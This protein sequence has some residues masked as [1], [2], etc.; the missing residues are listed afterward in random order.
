MIARRTVLLLLGLL[1]VAGPAL[2]QTSAQLL[3]KGIF[4]EDTVGDVDGAIKIY[5]QVLVARFLPRSVAEQAQL[6]LADS[7]RR[8]GQPQAAPGAAQVDP[9][10]C[11]GIFSR[12]YDVNRPV[13]VSGEVTQVSWI[14]PQSVVY[15]K[16]ND[17][18]L[19]GM[20]IAAPN[21]MIRVGMT[22]TSFKLGEQLLIDGFMAKGEG[23][24]CPAALPNACAQ[25]E[26]GALHGSARTIT[27]E[28]GRKIFDRGEAERALANAQ[29]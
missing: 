29:Q 22:K 28:D 23:A 25:F 1:L 19:W 26:N 24:P 20:T 3:E 16:G 9:N 5:R 7:L 12:N 18:N 6:R 8:K 2:A 4:T 13:T 11:C 27:S 17:G 21:A 15:V 14:N 10:S